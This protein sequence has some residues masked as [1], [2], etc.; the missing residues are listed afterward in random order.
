MRIISY[1]AIR[2]FIQRHPESEKVMKSWYDTSKKVIWLNF[3][4][5]KQTFGAVDL[6]KNNIHIFDIGGNK[7]R[8][9][10][11][12][13]YNTGTLYIREVLTHEEYDKNQWQ[14]RL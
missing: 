3:S 11:A 9:V 7:Y 10:A 5:V 13:H 4:E 14:K 8:L 1:K 2:E 6:F 12:I